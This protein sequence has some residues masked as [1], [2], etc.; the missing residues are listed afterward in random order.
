MLKVM[1]NKNKKQVATSKSKATNNNPVS[2]AEVKRKLKPGEITKIANKTG[3]SLGHVSNVLSG[4]RNNSEILKEA[5]RITR[6][7][8]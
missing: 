2:L 7:R 5:A 4:L 6:R 8:K 1:A 3:Y